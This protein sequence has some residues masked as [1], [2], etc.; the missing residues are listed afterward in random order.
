MATD[1]VKEGEKGKR[2]REGVTMAAEG[3]EGWRYVHMYRESERV[4]LCVRVGE[5]AKVEGGRWKEGRE[6]GRRREGD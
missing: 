4:S 2:K 6:G 1:R 5:K 3:G